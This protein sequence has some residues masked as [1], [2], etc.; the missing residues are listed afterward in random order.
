MLGSRLKLAR[1]KA[2]LSLRD[3]AELVEPRVSAQALSK[4]EN[5]VM[6]PSSRVLMGLARALNVSVD[7]LM[8][9]QVESLAG[10]EFRK[11]AG[12][13]ASERARVEAIVIE[14]LENYL[15]IED[16]LDMRGED[17]ALD[18]FTIEHIESYEEA[19]ELAIKLRNVWNLGEDAIPS[20]TDLLEDRGVRVVEADLSEGVSGMTCKVKRFDGRPPVS[21]IVISSKMTLERKRFTLAHELGHRLIHGVRGN[22]IQLERAMNRFA[23]AF[24][25]PATH[26]RREAGDQRTSISY[27]EIRR[28]KHLYGVSA[29]MLLYRISDLAILPKAAVDYAFKTYAKPWR[30]DEPDPLRDDGEFGTLERPSRFEGLVY[31]AL[32][33]N[34]IS[35]VRAANMLG[36]SLREIEDGLRW[37]RRA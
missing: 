17:G 15:A 34:L 11:G 19:E 35:S 10:V 32:A 37:P 3:L 16:I 5:D 8:G 6:M 12:T 24:L 22:A 14:K 26:L 25:V 1:A 27:H 7:F 36:V 9:A 18:K 28:L 20:L 2:G 29:A 21:A 13:S 33:E 4:Y 31:R 30:Y 23:G